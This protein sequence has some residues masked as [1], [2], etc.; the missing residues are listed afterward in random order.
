MK[1]FSIYITSAL[2]LSASLT[3]CSLDEVNYSSL[4]SDTYFT[5]ETQYEQLVSEAYLCMRPLLRINGPMW[6]GTDIITCQGD[7]VQSAVRTPMNDYTTVGGDEYL[8]LWRSCYNLITKIN[9]ALDRGK[10]IPD[11]AETLKSQRTA[12]LKALRAYAYFIL[13]ENFGGVPIILTESNTPQYS[14]T[15]KTEEEVYKQ[16]FQDLNEA[17]GALPE[18]VSSQDFG[19]V[20]KAFAYHLLAKI[21]LTHFYKQYGDKKN[22]LSQCIAYADKALALHPLLTTNAW[23]TLFGDYSNLKSPVS[24]NQKNQE[25][26][27]SVRY[28]ENQTYNGSWD[29]EESSWGNNLYQYFKPELEKFPCGSVTAGPYWHCQYEYEPTL[30]YTTLFDDNDIRGSET[31]LQRHIIA[32][33]TD[34]NYPSTKIGDEIIY[35]PKT[36]LS[37]K[38]ITNYK[39]QHPSVLF[40]VNPDKYNTYAYNTYTAFPIVWKFYDTGV[41]E[42]TNDQR[43]PKGTRD[44]YVFRSAETLLLKA[45]ALVQQGNG[46]TATALINQLRNRAGANTLTTAATIDD[47]LDES[48]RELFGEAN[49]WMDL[50]R[51]GKLFE[52]AWKY[53][54]WIQ[55]QYTSYT[56]ISN[57]NLLRPIPITEIA[58][59]GIEQNPGYPGST[60]SK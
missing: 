20:S 60:N 6:Y 38:E 35:C 55:K 54:P 58:N 36:A 53:N 15:R 23:K 26:I 7:A 49:R 22:D 47:V 41:T 25:I 17:E 37:D 40:V 30:F 42:Y 10:T 1:H 56:A 2:L 14:F 48:A 28:S 5:G 44:T 45:E 52:R 50:K 13:V 4:D 46:T 21:H 43:N 33:G 31:Y 59:S 57:N 8:A 29:T 32:A 11:V 12:E 19:R 51:T 9:T 3:A 27:Y 39:A 16:I 18:K 34:E 24:P